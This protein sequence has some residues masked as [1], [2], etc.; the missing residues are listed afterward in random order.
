MP[1]EFY[2]AIMLAFGIRVGSHDNEVK[3]D[4]EDEEENEWVT[5]TLA[6]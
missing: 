2:S 3:N 1:K 6:W 4:G 5:E